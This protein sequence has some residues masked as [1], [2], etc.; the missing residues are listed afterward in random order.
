[1]TKLTLSIATGDYD[2]T[3]PL[4]DGQV[5]IDGVDPIFMTLEPEEMFF[6]AVRHQEF[7]VTE[8]S[9]SSYT[10]LT[11][12]NRSAYIGIPVFLSRAFRHTSIY[13]RKDRSINRPADLRGKRIGTPEMQLTACV[14]GRGLL[15]DAGVRLTDVTWVRGG[16]ENTGRVEKLA[17][18]P[19][20]GVVIEDI[21]PDQT[22]SRM[23]A[24]GKIDAIISP[25]MPS[26]FATMPDRVGWLFPDPIAAA[27]EYY[28]RTK[29][30]PIMHI[31]GIRRS[32]VEQ[33][34]WLARALFKAFLQ[35][36]QICQTRLADTSAPK[37]MLPFVEET[38]HGAQSLI[39]Q[40]YWS[41]GVAGNEQALTE[42]LRLH[43]T[44]G[45]SPRL[46]TA[47]DL[48]PLPLDDIHK[49]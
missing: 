44:D 12:Q 4:I 16:M 45:L 42:F 5:R 48:F 13:I 20:P 23:L 19:P 21:P 30:F 49:I 22:L 29:I 17:F 10:L 8:L 33:H 11:A 26:C 46:L 39:G 6:R 37:V 1:M 9:L 27:S 34:S 18:T 31:V 24:E 40:D 2:R 35:S 32:L 43:H 38:M 7:D 41:Y 14:W 47:A 3:R 15:A 36:K 28:R 25:R